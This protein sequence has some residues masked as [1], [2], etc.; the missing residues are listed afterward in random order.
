MPTVNQQSAVNTWYLRLVNNLET[1]Y[2]FELAWNL[3]MMGRATAS[4]NVDINKPFLQQ[5]KTEILRAMLISIANK[6]PD[7]NYSDRELQELVIGAR[8]LGMDWPELDVIEDSVKPNITEGGF[9]AEERRQAMEYVDDL[10]E[11]ADSPEDC[12]YVFQFAYGHEVLFG[13][14]LKRFFAPHR[15]KWIRFLL[16]NMKDGYHFNYDEL[17]DAVKLLRMM[18]IRWPELDVIESGLRDALSERKGTPE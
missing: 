6:D 4:I 2:H 12:M 15:E 7:L 13:P 5:H 8:K 9:D 11:I 10:P 16:Q 18:D 3:I 1:K 14:Y 17:Y